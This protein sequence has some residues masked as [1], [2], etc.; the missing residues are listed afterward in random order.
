MVVFGGQEEK[1]G[2]GG[3]G[4][5]ERYSHLGHGMPL[6]HF[7]L[8]ELRYHIK[9]RQ[10]VNVSPG[11]DRNHDSAILKTLGPLNHA[12]AQVGEPSFPERAWIPARICHVK[13]LVV[14][15]KAFA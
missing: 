3:G 13:L 2:G 15:D 11:L 8:A 1:E 5:E 6:H 12:G 9:S 14:D 4:G 7:A 10:R